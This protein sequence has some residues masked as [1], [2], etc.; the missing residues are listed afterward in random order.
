MRWRPK[1]VVLR[2]ICNVTLCVE[3]TRLFHTKENSVEK[4]VGKRIEVE[5]N[6][7]QR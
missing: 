7:Q 6:I 2:R 1:F 3:C 5:K 4:E